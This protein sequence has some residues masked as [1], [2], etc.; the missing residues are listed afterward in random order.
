MAGFDPKASGAPS[1]LEPV[2]QVQP[3]A[4]ASRKRG[5]GV[6]QGALGA[7]P[8]RGLAPQGRTGTQ[9]AAWL[10]GRAAASVPTDSTVW[11]CGVAFSGSWWTMWES[12]PTPQATLE[13]A[14]W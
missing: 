6:G 9:G 8:V 13:A 11:L 4:L 2:G 5:K 3:P 10:R 1:V 14:Y 12:S 7:H